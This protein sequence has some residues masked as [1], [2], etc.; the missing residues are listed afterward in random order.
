MFLE[1]MN[2][3]FQFKTSRLL[4][5]IHDLFVVSV[6]VLDVL[7]HIFSILLF[8]LQRYCTLQDQTT[9]NT[10]HLELLQ[11]LLPLTFSEAFGNCSSQGSM[12]L[13]CV[14]NVTSLQEWNNFFL[15][16]LSLVAG[17]LQIKL[18]NDINRRKDIQVL[19]DVLLLY[20]IEVSQKMKSKPQRGSQ[21]Q[22]LI[23]HFN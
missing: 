20:G 2:D 4:H 9:A 7:L 13:R 17:T 16:P 10:S 22:R 18:T 8:Q 15:Y 11:A 21:I 1:Q 3:L 19:F 12:Q 23:H 5:C 6:N 14:G